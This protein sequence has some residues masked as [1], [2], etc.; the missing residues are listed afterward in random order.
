[1]SRHDEDD[2]VPSVSKI[3]TAAIVA[4]QNKLIAEVYGMLLA[5]RAEPGTPESASQ[6]SAAIDRIE[7][8]PQRR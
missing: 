6:I 5:A 3:A 1:M 4:S 2:E 8:Y 7:N